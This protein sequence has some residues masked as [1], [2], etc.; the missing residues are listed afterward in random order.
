M[1]KYEAKTKPTPESVDEFLANISDDTKRSD[2]QR[3]RELMESAT[4]EGG[5]MWG[6]SMVGFG[7]YHYRYASGHE[8]DTM[9]VGFAPRSA[10]ITLYITGGFEEHESV[11]QRLGKHKTGKGCLYIKRLS[12]V[13]E[14]ALIE[15]IE[16]SVA[17]AAEHNV[18]QA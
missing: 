14:S 6:A 1:V 12:D 3:L 8:G 7:A 16:A 15:L 17:M 5:R 10:N 13:D 4:G 11:L 18:T 9:A 2:C